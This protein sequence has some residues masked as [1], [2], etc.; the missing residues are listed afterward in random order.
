[1]SLDLG[2]TPARKTERF[3]SSILPL[4]NTL[5]PGLIETTS[6]AKAVLT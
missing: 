5:K 2:L 4:F 1:V 3:G 6:A